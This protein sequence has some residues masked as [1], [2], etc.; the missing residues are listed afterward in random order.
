MTNRKETKIICDAINDLFG[1][2]VCTPG[3]EKTVGQ[4]TKQELR[5]AKKELRRSEKELKRS[6]KKADKAA[7]RAAKQLN[8]F[9]GIK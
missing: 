8:K 4:M 2:E 1:C 5:A 7:L 6:A 3:A 9:R